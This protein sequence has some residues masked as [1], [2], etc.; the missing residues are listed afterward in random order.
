MNRRG[1]NNMKKIIPFRKDIIFKTN[2]SEITSI[3]LEHTL[4]FEDNNLISGVFTV[5]GDYKITDTSNLTEPFSYDLPFDINMDEKYNLERAQADI[6]DFYYEIINDNVLSVNIEVVVNDV[7]ERLIPEE[8]EPKEWEQEDILKEP[9]IERSQVDPALETEL[10]QTREDLEPT[11]IEHS[12]SESVSDIEME[13][14]MEASTVESTSPR[15]IE[16]ED[17][18][19]ESLF[20]HMDD[21]TETYQSYKVYIVREGDTLEAILEKYSVTKEALES[22]N[23]LKEIKIGDKIIVPTVHA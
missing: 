2:L 21:T 18:K 12:M 20:D 15:C 7:E 13:D 17:S 16:P 1:E 19:F 22:Y 10:E 4:H 3:S 5:S 9:E 11:Q 14:S 6:N 8:L 23:D